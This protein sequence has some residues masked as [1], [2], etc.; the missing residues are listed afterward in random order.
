MQYITE[1]RAI[2]RDVLSGDRTAFENLVRRYERLVLHIV[3][4]L[5]GVIADRED[6]CQDVFMKVYEKI[7][8]FRFDSKLSTW[9]GNIAYNT[10][11]NFLQKKKN[12]L[13]GDLFSNDKSG[14]HPLHEIIVEE[15]N[16]ENV[17]IKKEELARLSITI[18]KLP[19]MQKAVI[20]LFHYHDLSISDIGVILEMTENTVKSHLFRAR[21][22]LKEYLNKK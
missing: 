2:V 7:G 1:E 20:L 9:I 14:L 3:T 13:L 19:E 18:D 17:M 16:A 15:T 8:S 5:V 22:L 6:I 21:K 10:S 11:I 4:P 12:I